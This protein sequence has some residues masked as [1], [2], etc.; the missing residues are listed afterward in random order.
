LPENAV[1]LFEDETD[2]VLFPPL[3]A[4]WSKR[5]Q[6]KPVLLSGYNARRV[7]FGGLNAKTG[8]LLL[9]PEGRQRAVDFQNFLD[10]VRWHYRSRW[11]V[12]L[13]DEDASHTAIDSQACACDHDIE[14]WWLPRRS[15]ELNP[16]ERLWQAAKKRVCANYQHPDIEAQTMEFMHYLIGLS[17]VETLLTSGITSDNF[18]LLR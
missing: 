9:V 15:P 2:L 12:M 11:V 3:W 5:G 16:I 17:P 13:L 1:V 8:H 10:V 18:W 4:A 7:V 14:L 6:S